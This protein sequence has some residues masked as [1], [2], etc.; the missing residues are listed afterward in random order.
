MAVGVRCADHA[1]HLNSQKL[2]LT[3]PTSRYSSLAD[4]NPQNVLFYWPIALFSLTEP[5]Y[6][7]S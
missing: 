7:Y 3:S 2:T 5:F 1:E 4:Y 6:R